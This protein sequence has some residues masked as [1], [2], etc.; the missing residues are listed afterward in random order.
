MELTEAVKEMDDEAKE[1][2]EK[3]LAAIAAELPPV[4][5]KNWHKWRDVLPVAPGTIAND[6]SLGKGPKDFV[7]MGRVK[8]Y[9]R[10]AMIDYLRE[11][12]RFT[13]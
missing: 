8:G 7:F 11:K 3:F 13:A 1:K 9:S 5:F 6:D 4:V 12:I 10:A 2:R